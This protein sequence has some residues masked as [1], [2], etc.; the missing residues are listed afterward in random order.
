[1]PA[2]GP[3]SPGGL[4][5]QTKTQLGALYKQ[6]EAV[7]RVSER[8]ALLFEPVIGSPFERRPLG[9]REVRFRFGAEATHLAAVLQ[10]LPR[11]L[12]VDLAEEGDV[13][14]GV[15]EDA[16]PG[17]HV[18]NQNI[19][20]WR[21]RT[22]LLASS[23]GFHLANSKPARGIKAGPRRSRRAI[24]VFLGPTKAPNDTGGGP[25]ERKRN[26]LVRNKDV[27]IIGRD[28]LYV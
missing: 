28:A 23:E 17:V 13:Q 24:W 22:E 21:C 18:V 25:Y 15:R 26:A 8:S 10:S 14:T 2:R 19:I 20:G 11:E 5:S 16:L 1:M 9:V 3:K 7:L 27:A 4:L 12:F 6:P